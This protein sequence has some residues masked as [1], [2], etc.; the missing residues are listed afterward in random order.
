MI[1][2]KASTRTGAYI[3]VITLIVILGVVAIISQNFMHDRIDLTADKQFT[4]SKASKNTLAALPD[5]VTIKAVISKDLPTQ[6][7]QIRTHVVDLL[8]EF[9]AQSD[10]KVTLVFDD[11][12][13]NDKKRTDATSLGIQEVQLQEQSSQGMEI[14]KGF[15]GIALLYGDKK[16]VIPVLQNLQ[17]F[18]YDIIVKLKKLTE[19]T[20]TL[21]IVE[22]Q[23]GS[24]FVLDLPGPQ[25]QQTRGFDDNF[26][27]LKEEARKLY[28]IKKVD[29]QTGPVPDD[30]DLL[31]IA[32]PQRLSD[33]EKFHIDQFIMTGKSALF[34]TPGVNINLGM[35]INGN[36][37]DNNYEDLLAHYGLSVK[38][39]LILEDQN[40]QLV[41]FGNSFFPSPYPFWII[42]GGEDLNLTN[43]IT[44]KLGAVSLPWTSSIDID[45]SKIDSTS[46][47]EILVSSSAGSW[48]ESGNFFLLPKDLK[49]YLPVDQKQHPLAVLKSGGFTSFYSDR[50]LPDTAMDPTSVL[51]STN[52]PSRILVV[53][54]AL[55]PT[56]FFIGYTNSVS[57]L[58]F[59][60]NSFDQLALDPDL[61]TIRSR[62]IN[63]VPILEDKKAL[64]YPILLVNMAAAP[65]LLMIIGVVMVVRRKKMESAA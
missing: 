17:S 2:K 23:E 43:N 62:E 30:V 61:I 3:S 47:V 21:G 35:G 1:S 20:K 60:L 40:F 34:L 38:K 44:S 11:P 53:G 57:N 19:G 26:P 46:Q 64:Q 41:R 39:N 10:G 25:A 56:D 15:F 4:L 58:H 33:M 59:M 37:S 9:E 63:S 18:E 51:K 36:A 28:E 50:P 5:I 27:T 48:E 29:A 31:V 7:M 24:R 49:E 42:T 65:L 8:Q 12:G 55:F 45:S 16:E 54:N 6:F 32:A 13:E 14:K 22:G 52:E